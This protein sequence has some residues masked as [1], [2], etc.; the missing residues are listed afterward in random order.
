MWFDPL[1]FDAI[2]SPL[3]RLYSQPGI[4]C[5]IQASTN[6]RNWSTLATVTNTTGTVT[7]TDTQGLPKCFYKARQA[8]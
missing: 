2:G 7:F 8:P 3:L 5:E 4:A 1:T 6:L